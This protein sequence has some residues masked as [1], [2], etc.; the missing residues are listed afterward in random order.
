MENGIERIGVHLPS[1]AAYL[2]NFVVLLGVLYLIAYRPFLR[3]LSQREVRLHDAES[4]IKEGE[5][6]VVAARMSAD[7]L[8]HEAREEARQVLVRAHETAAAEHERARAQSRRVFEDHMR[9]ARW[10]TEA[11]RRRM[12]AEL[13]RET[14]DLAALAAEKALGEIIDKKKQQEL[15]SRAL[16]QV[17]SGSQG[18]PAGRG[19]PFVR[20]SAAS[21]LSQEQ[22]A[23]VTKAVERM[24]GRPAAVVSAAEPNLLGGMSLTAGGRLMD[25]SVRGRL[26]SVHA[27]MRSGP[28]RGT[29]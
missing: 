14:A 10:E 23:E 29:A 7:R 2:I 5:E 20:V 11:L 24:L 21:P 12:A 9:R 18:L 16:R 26:V 27:R 4:R 28:L 25:A 13:Q 6:V 17:T 1:L 19:V 8:I 22:I 15:F 3:A